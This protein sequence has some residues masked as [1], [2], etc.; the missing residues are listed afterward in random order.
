MREEYLMKYDGKKIRFDLPP[1][2]NGKFPHH[3]IGVLCYHKQQGFW[4]IFMDGDSVVLLHDA[5]IEQIEFDCDTQ[6]LALDFVPG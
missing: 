1:G 3:G 2:S 5:M 6:A 4:E